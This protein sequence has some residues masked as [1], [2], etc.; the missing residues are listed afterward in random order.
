M[1]SPWTVPIMRQNS[2]NRLH[3]MS[4]LHISLLN[5]TGYDPFRHFRSDPMEVIGNQLRTKQLR[6]LPSLF[7]LVENDATAS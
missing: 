1:N 4:Q 6:M 7:S 5:A 2:R 3:P